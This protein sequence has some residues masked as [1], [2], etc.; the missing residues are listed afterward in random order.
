MICNKFFCSENS[1]FTSK[2]PVNRWMG[3]PLTHASYI[4]V[5]LIIMKGILIS[6]EKE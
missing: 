5:C 4:Y 2:E 6:S 1:G 3:K